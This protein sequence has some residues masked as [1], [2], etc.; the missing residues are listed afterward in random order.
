[1]RQFQTAGHRIVFIVGDYTALI[2]DPTGRN[3]LRP[4]LTPEQIAVNAQTYREQ[5]IK[6]L[7]P[8]RTEFVNNSTWLSKLSFRDI[9]ELAS[10]YNLGRMLER[11]DFKER[12]E[13]GK[14]IA[15]HEFLYPLMQGHDSVALRADVELG[16]ADQI[17]NLNV[18]RHLMA[19]G[20]MSPQVC[21]TVP[22]LVGLD[23]VEKMSKSKGNHVG[24]T[25]PPPDMF[26]KV[27]SISD[28]TMQGW[29]PLLLG[30]DADA[31]RPLEEKKALAHA[32][33]ARFH[34]AEAAERTL[35]W[36]NAGRPAEDVPEFEVAAGQLP[37]IMVAVG[38]A[39]SNSD[40][41]RKIAQG[42]VSLDEVLVSS[43]VHE[44]SAGSYLLRVGKKNLARLQVKT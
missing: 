19:A 33:V 43:P 22:L 14:Q 2:G 36:W 25:E 42:G 8:E 3:T 40:A 26:G 18:G 24:I 31:A 39:K 30:R 5:A 20:N 1:M 32:L 28:V 23:G 6:I 29:Y 35:A 44:L 21:M 41:R 16:G 4:P 17:F 7:D 37:S 12:F 9:I 10:K 11:R 34:G 38:L 27:M 13:S 15:L